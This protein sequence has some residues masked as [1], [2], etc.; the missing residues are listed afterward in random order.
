M[1]TIQPTTN[2]RRG[3]HSRE[4]TAERLLLSSAKQ[5][6][7]PLVDIDW[8]SPHL[9]DT[10]YMQP[11][12]T[13]LYGTPLWNGLDQWQRLELTKHQLASTYASGIFFEMILMRM[14]LRHLG[15]HD[16]R[17]HHFQ[18]G[19]T[20]VADECRHSTMFGKML[21]WLDTPAYGPNTTI[22]HSSEILTT[23]LSNDAVAF[24]G[25][26]YVEALLDALQREGMNDERTQPVSRK[27]AY[28]HVVEEARHMRYAD[29]ELA[30]DLDELKGWDVQRTRAF[31]PLIA[32]IVN[33]LL[34]HPRGYAAAGLDIGQAKAA[35][36]SNPEWQQT[37]RWA[38]SKPMG[39]FAELGLV[40]G[41]SKAIWKR[42]GLV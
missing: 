15:A 16:P 35:A 31:L 38:A 20:E 10:W 7:D 26:F 21:T 22:R 8:N 2:G 5:S 27:V 11:E 29:E 18:Y 17:S 42:T 25:T 14:L 37:L 41:P 39:V 30:R 4:T 1:T 9:P 40:K 33:Q 19:L 28:I 36:A 6:F 23:P 12:R 3:A 24:A 32:L 13:T 34:M